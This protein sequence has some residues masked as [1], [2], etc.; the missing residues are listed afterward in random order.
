[1]QLLNVQPFPTT[2]H[3]SFRGAT[4][5]VSPVVNASWLQSNNTAAVN[6]PARPEGVVPSWRLLDVSKPIQLPR[7]CFAVFEA[8]VERGA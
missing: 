8:A 2:L 7:N 6:T 1:V 5:L 3:L 4:A